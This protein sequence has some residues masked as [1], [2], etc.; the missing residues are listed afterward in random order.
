MPQGVRHRAGQ[1]GPFAYRLML[2]R[3]EHYR[4]H[5]GVYGAP[6]NDVPADLCLLGAR[7]TLDLQANGAIG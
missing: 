7:T 5:R 3:P 4:L 2:R 6:G 1:S